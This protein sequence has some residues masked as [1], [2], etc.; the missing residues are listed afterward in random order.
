VLHLELLPGNSESLNDRDG[1]WDLELERLKQLD[2]L[3][4]AGM[5]EPPGVPQQGVL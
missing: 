4:G 3:D 2:N 5:L 1:V